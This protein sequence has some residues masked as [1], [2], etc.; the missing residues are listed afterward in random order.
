MVRGSEA[1]HER[2]MR[3]KFA[4][5]DWERKLAENVNIRKE[6]MNQL[7]MNFLV[8]E[9]YVDAARIFERE[10]G[11][12]PGIDLSVIT[13]RMEIRKAVQS[14]QVEEAID[15]VNDLNPEILEEQHQLSFHLQQQQLIELIRAGKLEEA[16]E[17][18]Q[19]YLAPQAQECPEFLEELERTVSLLAFDNVKDSPV[20]DLLDIAQRQKTATEL[21]AAILSS[22]CQEKEPRLPYLLKMMIWAQ[23]QLDPKTYPRMT[24][25]VDGTLSPP[26]E[27]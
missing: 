7:I 5:E 13:D 10:S 21:N 16:L 11:T 24:N 17:F 23:N 27:D 14:G 18:A 2:D 6:D 20:S 25:L 8:T 9:G 12:V 19:E 26:S 22:Q 4:L 3:R 1:A 15:K